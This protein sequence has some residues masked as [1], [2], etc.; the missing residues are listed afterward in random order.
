MWYRHFHRIRFQL[1]ILKGFLLENN[2]W[3]YEGVCWSNKDA[4]TFW[5]THSYLWNAHYSCCKNSQLR[6][7]FLKKARWINKNY[8]KKKNEMTITTGK[9]QGIKTIPR[10]FCFPSCMENWIQNISVF[11]VGITIDR[12]SISLVFSQ[13]C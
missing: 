1:I 12:S 3:K 13:K 8:K 10:A 5:S 11:P 2:S 9:M 4:R 6:C 7:A